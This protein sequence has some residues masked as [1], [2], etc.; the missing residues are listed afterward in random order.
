[1]PIAQG[2]KGFM[3]WQFRMER[4][5]PEWGYGLTNIDGSWSNRCDV[6]RE[7]AAFFH[8]HADLLLAAQVMDYPA[9]VGYALQTPMLEFISRNVPWFSAESIMGAYKLTLHQD[10]PTSFV[11]IDE[12]AVDDDFNRFKLITLPATLYVSEKAAAKLRKF[13]RQGGTL[14]ADAGLGEF[15]A[16][17]CW[18]A[19]A[20]PG[21]G[22]DE[23]FGVRRVE[24]RSIPKGARSY[25]DTPSPVLHTINGR[26]FKTCNLQEWLQPTTA[27][28]IGEWSDGSPAVTVN[29][30]GKGKAVYIGSGAFCAFTHNHN[31]ALQQFYRELCADI[32]RPAWTDRNETHVRVLKRGRQRVYFVFNYYNHPVATRLTIPGHRGDLYD[33]WHENTVATEAGPHGADLRLEMRPFETRIFVNHK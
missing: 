33:L 22:L 2:A 15:T 5:G 32:A 18:W 1:M 23:L 21:Q 6:A 3:Y 11:R 7:C 31:D 20:V 27:K 26:D 16:D 14:V 28:V 9:A 24:A 13:V 8:K 4:K 25:E 17:Q 19:T 10:I 30:Y 29:Q 12:E